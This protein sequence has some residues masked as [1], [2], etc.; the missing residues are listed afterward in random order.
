MI[1]VNITIIKM[2][3]NNGTSFNL[4]IFQSSSGSDGESPSDHHADGLAPSAS[5]TD[6]AVPRASAEHKSGPGTWGRRVR[7]NSDAIKHAFFGSNQPEAER[8]SQL[9]TVMQGELAHTAGGDSSAENPYRS[10]EIYSSQSSPTQEDEYLR[11][12][13]N[14]TATPGTTT[15][16]SQPAHADAT[17]DPGALKEAESLLRAHMP[18]IHVS[19]PAPEGMLVKFYMHSLTKCNSVFVFCYKYIA[20]LLRTNNGNYAHG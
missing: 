6:G 19:S 18:D 3:S 14:G 17:Q 5:A 8:E 20:N 12:F 15:D 7:F 16:G 13:E 11:S 2:S 9:S 4:N 1:V 10:D